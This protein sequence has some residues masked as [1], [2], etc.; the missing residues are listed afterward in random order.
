MSKLVRSELNLKNKKF[1]IDVQNWFRPSFLHFK[2]NSTF[3]ILKLI[4]RWSS[5]KTVFRFWQIFLSN[6]DQAEGCRKE[7]RR[8]YYPVDLT[9]FRELLEKKKKKN[10]NLINFL[11]NFVSCFPNFLLEIPFLPLSLQIFFKFSTN[12]SMYSWK[13]FHA[14]LKWISYCF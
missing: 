6:I 8:K 14:I 1:R 13:E 12:F 7:R 5:R 2:I 4:E 10:E 3:K 9:F 11:S